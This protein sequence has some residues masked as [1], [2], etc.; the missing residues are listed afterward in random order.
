MA[1]SFK[2]TIYTFKKLNGLKNSEYT[3]KL[4]KSTSNKNINFFNKILNFFLAKNSV[5]YWNKA[6]YS[7][8]L[9]RTSLQWRPEL[10]RKNCMLP[11]KTP[12]LQYQKIRGIST[13]NWLLKYLP[14]AFMCDVSDKTTFKILTNSLFNLYD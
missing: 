9:E 11:I 7:Q 13:S 14:E 10:T 12:I 1:F 4:F 6:L 8:A 3:L 5:V 2:I